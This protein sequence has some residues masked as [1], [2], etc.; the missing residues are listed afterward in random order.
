M[1]KEHRDIKKFFKNISKIEFKKVH[2]DFLK[3]CLYPIP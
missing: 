2:K 3:C 1:Y